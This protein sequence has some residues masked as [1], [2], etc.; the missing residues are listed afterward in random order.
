M[1]LESKDLYF[2]LVSFDRV[3]KSA[4]SVPDEESTNCHSTAVHYIHSGLADHA[5]FCN[6]SLLR[7]GKS[8]HAHGLL[9]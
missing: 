6:S 1:S 8:Q 9:Q 4:A 2:Q 5:V 3:C 7:V